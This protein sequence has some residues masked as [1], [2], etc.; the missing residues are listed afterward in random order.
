MFGVGHIHDAVAQFY[1]TGVVSVCRFFQT[2][3]FV[4]V[5][6]AMWKS[7]GGKSLADSKEPQL[8]N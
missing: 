4:Y 8:S 2:V 5:V 1:P 6:F 7:L 3:F